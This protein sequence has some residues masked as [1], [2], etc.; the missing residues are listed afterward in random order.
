MSTVEGRLS[1]RDSAVPPAG[2]RRIGIV[3]NGVTGRM[4]TNQHLVRSILGIQRQGGLDCGAR[5]VL[6]PGP[7]LGGRSERK[8]RHLAEAHGVPRWSTDLGSCLADPSNEV[9]F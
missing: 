4:G 1:V 3:M 9:Y 8:V 7:V 2:A 5:G 6:W